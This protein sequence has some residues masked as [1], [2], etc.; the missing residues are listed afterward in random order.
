[1]KN[2]LIITQKV[3]E[4]DQLL[5]FFIEWIRK[6]ALHFEKVNVLCLEKGQYELPPNVEVVSLGKDRRLPK[7]W[8][9]FN[10]YKYTFKKRKEYDAVFVHMNPRYVVYG[11]WFWKLTGKKVSL[12]YA[13]GHVG[14]MLKF[15]AVLADTVFTSTA[16]GFRLKSGRTVVVGQGI[17]TGLFKPNLQFPIFN[18]QFKIVSVGRIS[19]SKDYETLI[20]AV[21]LLENENV[22]VEIAGEPA[23]K[24]DLEYLSEL[25]I[26]I[27]E[28]NLTSKIKFIGL[29]TNRELPKFLQS[30][31]IFVNMSHTGSLDKAVLE[32]MSCG[33][34]VLTC[35]EALRGVLGSYANE[36][37]YPKKDDKKLADGL[38][39]L[40]AMSGEEREKL[41]LVL[42]EIVVK[43]HN[44]EGLINKISNPLGATANNNDFGEI[45][46]RKVRQNEGQYEQQRWFKNPV[47]RAGYEMTK[48]SIQRHLIE[49]DL[50]F[51]HCLEVGPGPGTWTKLLLKKNPEADYDLVDI[52]SEMLNLAKKNMGD[53]PHVKYFLDDFM[54]FN[55]DKKY[56]LFFS[57]RAIEYFKDK[58]GAIKKIYDL[59]QSGGL[60][61]IITKTPHYL[62]AKLR[63]RKIN[64]MHLG[65][66]KP[67]DMRT[68][69]VRSG[70][71]NVEIYSATAIFPLLRSP[72]LN[73][74]TFYVFRNFKLNPIS[75]FF[76]ESYVVKFQKP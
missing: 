68:V 11:G 60:G 63:G 22:S 44:L 49:R 58:E 55:P 25:K 24:N 39:K 2:L 64:D 75:K 53:T 6:F 59:M 57:S 32:A 7:I 1:M 28:N 54:K 56:D 8:W 51:K 73:K 5:G 62:R 36:L 41:G 76:S 33:L 67:L 40:I 12:W 72:F 47:A 14:L 69:L 26:K 50:K 70:F 38:R 74:L 16:E 61:L 21:K 52:S 37:M 29:I 15:A 23:V 48:W 43:N 10:F 27:K 66:I 31:D 17:D 18:F 9:L 71:K 34:P 65:Q 35:N 42:R 3:D 20:R 4:N 45:Y 30:A 46:N 19:P 13:H